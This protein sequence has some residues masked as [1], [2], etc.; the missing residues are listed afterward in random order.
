MSRPIS[1]SDAL[2]QKPHNMTSHHKIRWLTTV[3]PSYHTQKVVNAHAYD[4]SDE[5]NEMEMN[6]CAAVA[7]MRGGDSSVFGRPFLTITP[8]LL[9]YTHR[10]S[11]LPRLALVPLVIWNYSK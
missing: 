6:T 4:S 9:A 11:L 3:C 2:V 5:R 7:I 1:F 8:L 10:S